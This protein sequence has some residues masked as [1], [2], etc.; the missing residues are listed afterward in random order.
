MALMNT[1]VIDKINEQIDGIIAY[2]DNI[3]DLINE[4]IAATQG[5]AQ[6]FID[7]KAQELSEEISEKGAY[8]REK[9]VEI[10]KAQYQSALEKVK[11]IQ[12][13]VN[14]Q[15]SMDTILT[16]VQSIINIIA[17]PYQPIIEF[18]TQV[19]PKV[20]ELSNNLQKLASYQ[21]NINLPDG[22]QPPKMDIEIEPITAA[23]ITGG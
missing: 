23:D 2:A 4:E 18:T 12:E 3:T 7:E 17:A 5:V 1:E 6:E 8:I 9:I 19:V 14:M 13:L 16:V 20:I 21:P 15:L 22:I 11:P 10:F